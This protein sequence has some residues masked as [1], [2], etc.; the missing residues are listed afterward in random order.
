M[1]IKLK[2]NLYVGPV[3]IFPNF[4]HYCMASL[5]LSELE[6][7]PHRN[8]GCGFMSRPI[9]VFNILLYIF[10]LMSR[11]SYVFNILLYI[12]SLMSRPSYVFNIL[13]YIFSLMSRP[14]YVFNMP[15]YI[16]SDQLIHYCNMWL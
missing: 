5:G 2:S 7:F 8:Y 14:S 3:N 1:T 12:F 9:Y 6:D 15:L 4:L 13:L 11:P 10:S 16:F